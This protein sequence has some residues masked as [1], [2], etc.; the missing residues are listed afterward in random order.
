LLPDV[1][2]VHGMPDKNPNLESLVVGG[3]PIIQKFVDRLDL[4]RHL[5]ASVRTRRLGRPPKV[6]SAQTLVAML[7]NILL[8]RLPLYAVGEWLG[9]HVPEHFGLRPDDLEHMNDDRIGRALD[10][11]YQSDRASLMTSVVTH[12]VKAFDIDLKQIHSDTT[13]VTFSGKYLPRA[14]KNSAKPPPKITFGHNKDHRPD[15]KQLVYGLG[16]S[17]D[18]AVPVYCRVY[19]GNTSDDS[20]HLGTWTTL[21][22]IVARPDFIYV[23]D[24]KLAV[25][26]SMMFIHEQGGRFVTVLP[27]TRKET[28]AFR[29]YARNEF[30]PWQEVRRTKNLRRR[31]G[32]P[33]VYGVFEPT[34]RSAEGFRIIW[35][36]STE[37]AK[38][39]ADIRSDKIACAKQRIHEL[40]MRRG[41]HRLRTEETALAAAN[42]I[43]VDEGA[44]RWLRVTTTMNT[45]KSFRQ[46][47]RG[48][49]SDITPCRQ[50]ETSYIMF[51]I[52]EI[53]DAIQQDARCDG[54]FP[55]ITN[56]E[57]ADPA[58]VLDIYKY[59][60]F[61]E[62]RNEQL[63]SA[64]DVAPVNLKSPERVAALLFLYFLALLVFALIERELREEM[65]RNKIASLPLY[66]EKRYCVAPTTEV[67]LDSVAGRRRHRLI[68]GDG[69]VIN[70]FHDPLSPVAKQ[71]LEL[72]G[73]DIRAY[74]VT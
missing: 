20:T 24:S 67:I 71:V 28:A 29:E 51:G 1:L 21:R 2:K 55:L 43:L 61:L 15:L 12:A 33:T 11:L 4:I 39:D 72:L 16:I 40:E 6:S 58:R 73:V 9:E 41:P 14:A 3:A 56:I 35:Y 13:T 57:D 42:K 26:E 53:A 27:K 69:C 74:R 64:L 45:V 22:D 30:V 32:P 44:E 31:N 23:A 59:Q 70:V 65:R 68:D 63:K 7:S 37:K 34:T 19:D 36:R 54:I 47:R 49:P 66:P 10:D 25:R 18:G 62:K 8:S 60:P 38:D 46:A 50:V 48:R 17:S 5:A 52:V